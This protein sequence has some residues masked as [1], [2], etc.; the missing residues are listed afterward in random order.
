MTYYNPGSANPC[1]GY[2]L[3][4]IY[5]KPIWKRPQGR[6]E[7]KNR[8]AR[9]GILREARSQGHARERVASSIWKTACNWYVFHGILKPLD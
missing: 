7:S 8:T 1:I 9:W 5:F 4:F 2:S 6:T 3:F